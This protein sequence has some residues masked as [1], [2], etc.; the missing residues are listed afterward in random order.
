MRRL[1]LS[2]FLLLI[3]SFAF[4]ELDITSI[5][6]KNINNGWSNLGADSND[7]QYVYATGLEDLQVSVRATGGQDIQNVEVF[8]DPVAVSMD[9][10]LAQADS[11]RNL[12]RLANRITASQDGSWEGTIIFPAN[13]YLSGKYKLG[14]SISGPRE[15]TYRMWWRGCSNQGDC[16]I[17]EFN[18]RVPQSGAAQTSQ[19]ITNPPIVL[20]FKPGHLAKTFTIGDAALDRGDILIQPELSGTGTGCFSFKK[21]NG[22]FTDVVTA[23]GGTQ[24]TLN[25]EVM[26]RPLCGVCNTPDAYPFYDKIVYSFARMPNARYEQ[27]LVVLCDADV[28]FLTDFGILNKAEVEQSLKD[29][30]YALRAEGKGVWVVDLNDQKTMH[31]LGL[32]TSG[33]GISSEGEVK[34]AVD[35]V[36]ADTDETRRA[37]LQE[38]SK[39]YLVIGGGVDVI[40]M[41]E[42]IQ[43]S[44]E[45]TGWFN[46]LNDYCYAQI[47]YAGGMCTFQ[48]GEVF[49]PNVIIARMPTEKTPQKGTDLLEKVNARLLIEILETASEKREIERKL[50][51]I[52]PQCGAVNKEDYDAAKCWQRWIVDEFLLKRL[53]DVGLT[54]NAYLSPSKCLGG[55]EFGLC[56]TDELLRVIPRKG[57]LYVRGHGSGG[58]I[59]SNALV[60][61][62]TDGTPQVLDPVPY[63]A[64]DPYTGAALSFP[65]QET[66]HPSLDLP[67]DY[68]QGSLHFYSACFMGSPDYKYP[69]VDKNKRII[70]LEERVLMNNENSVFM[71]F[72]HQGL[73][74]SIGC[75]TLINYERTGSIEREDEAK[76][77]QNFFEF[78]TIGEA[79][80]NF[81]RT[82]PTNPWVSNYDKN[83]LQLYGDPTI[84][85]VDAT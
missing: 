42:T 68:F 75:T 63:R 66:I 61:E 37:T 62:T 19:P 54:V 35:K 23:N 13:F 64:A 2:L 83:C 71:S 17:V 45:A 3:S 55:D 80:D 48:S 10:N 34:T 36:L 31:A 77:L 65:R 1:S 22:N 84:R 8:F 46:P 18:P 39:T 51:V 25:F 58:V 6:V 24:N 29:W 20:T 43:Y 26:V 79:F 9:G 32:S 5:T 30:I 53:E 59:T 76:L 16:G 33:G 28:V 11:A 44:S 38:E 74:A 56:S 60:G 47:S 81:K 14:V 57:I 4:S 82:Q 12:I 40:P 70:P 27:P 73:S 50:T 67:R 49:I 21:P 72:M 41:P 85:L 69:I 7:P 78:E 15:S 52:R